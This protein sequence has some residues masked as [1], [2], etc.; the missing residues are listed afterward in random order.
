MPAIEGT[1]APGFEKV[2]D[3]FTA[4][5]DDAGEVGAACCVYVDGR[6]VVDLWGGVADPDDGRPWRHDTPVLI[7]SAAKGLTAVCVHRLVE[8]GE[9]DLDAPVAAYWPEFGAEGKDGI[10]LRWVLSHRAGVAAVDAPVTLEDIVGWHGVV[11]AV[12][13]QA[14]NWE[15]GTAHGYHARTFGWILGEVVRRVTGK[16]LGAFLATEVAG[17]LDLD[18]WIGLPEAI[19]PRLAPII[20]PDPPADP[21]FRALLDSMLA[22][23]SLFGRVLTGPSNLFNYDGRWNERPLLGAEM[24]SSN[25]VATATAAARLYAATVSEVDG[26]RLL[27]PATVDAARTVQSDGPD[28]VLARDTR[29]GLGFMLPPLLGPECPPTAFGHSGAGGALAFADAEQALGFGYVMNRMK[30]DPSDPDLRSHGLVR[31]VYDCM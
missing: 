3:V 19:E 24:P 22:S 25:A 6:P 17:P 1:V 15:P 5:F 10:T 31:A 12:A 11:A 23:D 30:L 2:A 7:F 26:V 27:A 21:Q 8:R 20:P 9:L 4:N 14:P 29:F 13:A 16:S 18:V 28:C